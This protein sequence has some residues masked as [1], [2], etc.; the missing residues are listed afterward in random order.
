MSPLRARHVEVAVAR[1]ILIV[2][3]FQPGGSCRSWMGHIDTYI[4]TYHNISEVGQVVAR[5]IG[6]YINSCAHIYIYSSHYSHYSHCSPSCPSTFTW[7]KHQP[8]HFLELLTLGQDVLAQNACR[9]EGD[10][11]YRTYLVKQTLLLWW[12]LQAR[13]SGFL[14]PCPLNISELPSKMH[15]FII[16]HP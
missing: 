4:T 9:L 6:L 13:N 10:L 12:F 11:H 15:H 8:K 2:V 7:T 16:F 14:S 1:D 5:Y 3:G